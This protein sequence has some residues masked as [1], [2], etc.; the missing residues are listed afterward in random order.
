MKIFSWNVTGVGQK[1]FK[2]QL[3][4]LVITYKP[5]IDILM[6]TK[7]IQIEHKKMK[8]LNTQIFIETSPKSF[9]RAILLF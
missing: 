3:K 1:R 6:E 8:S 9:S 7:V 5:N 4:D 2:Y